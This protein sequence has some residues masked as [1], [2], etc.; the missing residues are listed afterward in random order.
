MWCENFDYKRNGKNSYASILLFLDVTWGVYAMVSPNRRN[1]KQDSYKYENDEKYEGAKVPNSVGNLEHYNYSEMESILKKAGFQ[2]IISI[3]MHDITL[4]D[5]FN[6]Q[7]MIESVEVN[8]RTLRKGVVYEP[9]VLITINYH[10][11]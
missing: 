7:G 4:V 6:R 5:L 10:G 2:N 11:K 1:E 3:N 8:G 9:D